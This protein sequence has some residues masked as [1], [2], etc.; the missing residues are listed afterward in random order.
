MRANSGPSKLRIVA[1]FP[2]THGSVRVEPEEAPVDASGS[3]DLT[4]GKVT[5][6]NAIEMLNVLVKRPETSDCMA[7]QWLRF[8]LGREEIPVGHKVLVVHDRGSRTVDVE[9]WAAL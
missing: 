1:E 5:F 8:A 2:L 4:S 6:K 3:F 9:P 7:K